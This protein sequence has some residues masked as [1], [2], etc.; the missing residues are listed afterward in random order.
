MALL[1]SWGKRFYDDREGDWKKILGHKYDTS[2]PNL[3][4]AR[5]VQGSP[6]W[7]SVS[8]AF[9]AS[10][11]FYKWS[12]GDGA[13]ILFWHDKWLGEYSLKVL[14]WDLFDICQ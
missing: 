3:F 9:T 2:S 6:F 11:V 14:F 10:K 8:W 7:K 4:N 1:A 12:L 5:S 13:N